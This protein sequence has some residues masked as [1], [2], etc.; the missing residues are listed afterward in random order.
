MNRRVKKKVKRKV[1]TWVKLTAV[2]VVVAIIVGLYIY[3]WYQEKLNAVDPTGQI[4]VEEEIE[5]EPPETGEISEIGEVVE[6]EAPLKYTLLKEGDILID[7]GETEILVGYKGEDIA[8]D[9]G[10]EYFVSLEDSEI[11][12]IKEKVDVGHVIGKD[13][14]MGE[15]IMLGDRFSIATIPSGESFATYL[16]YRDCTFLSLGN[17]DGE[18]ERLVAADIPVPDVVIASSDGENDENYYI[19]NREVRLIAVHNDDPFKVNKEL[20]SQ[21]APVYVTGQTGDLTFSTTG[22]VVT[23]AFDVGD[24]ITKQRLEMI[25]EERKA[26]EAKKAE[27]EKA[28]EKKEETKKEESTEK[29]EGGSN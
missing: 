28:A 12:A 9:G 4:V 5:E 29:K 23:P 21:E 18:G 26:E 27:E 19:S 20:L 17:L 7:Y 13:V 25:E 22:S 2:G 3:N 16:V 1:K 15:T 11:S 6:L 24:N 8:I 10:L 14:D